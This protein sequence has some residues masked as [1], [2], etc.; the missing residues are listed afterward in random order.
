M[1][2]LGLLVS[3]VDIIPS[4]GLCEG[5]DGFLKTVTCEGNCA[6]VVPTYELDE[7]VMF[8]GNKSELVRLANK[9][10]AMPFHHKVF[11]YNQ[12]ATNFSR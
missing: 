5:L 3:D 10:L 7:R 9:G 4:I 8:P 1:S 12:Y 2:K 11:I 6:F